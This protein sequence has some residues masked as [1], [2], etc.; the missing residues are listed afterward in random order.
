MNYSQAVKSHITEARVIQTIQ[1]Q[2]ELEIRRKLNKEEARIIF[3]Q[4]T[5]N[6]FLNDI[7][8]VYEST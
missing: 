4:T 3:S 2:A 8:K 1:S 7:K 5:P 6:I